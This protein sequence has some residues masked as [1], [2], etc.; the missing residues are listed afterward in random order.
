[1][2]TLE[3][4]K[5]EYSSDAIAL[6]AYITNSPTSLQCYSEA[7]IKSQGS[8]SLKGIASTAASG[9]T[10][11]HNLSCPTDLT[12]VNN[13]TFDLRSSRTGENIKLGLYS[14]AVP[15]GG[16]VFLSGGYE[17]HVFNQSG[18]FVLP[19]AATAEVLMVA[20]GGAGGGTSDGNGSGGGGAGGLLFYGTGGPKTPNGAA[21]SLTPGVYPVTV[22][23]GGVAANGQQGNNGGNTTFTSLIASGGGGGGNR[24]AGPGKAGGSGGGGTNVQPN[25]GAGVTGQGNKGG[26]GSYNSPY[27]GAGGGGGASAAGTNGTNMGGGVGGA[28]YSY[29]TW[30]GTSV[31]DG[32]A[33]AG[34]GGGE[35]YT[36]A[37]GDGA[38]GLGGGG[39]GRWGT[40]SESGVPNSGGGGGGAGELTNGAAG[41]GGDGIVIIKIP[42]VSTTEKLSITPNITT[43]G[44]FQ[45]IDWDISETATADKNNLNHLKIEIVNATAANTFYIDNL[46]IAPTQTLIQDVLGLIE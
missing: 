2:A 7:T 21:I 40:P 13:L 5:M 33:F 16:S 36:A 14:G 22:G 10:I 19:A 29:A 43:A 42:A 30:C 1:M 3:I 26:D 6:S 17:F 34:G 44:E 37:G 28:G 9:M 32:G 20:G 27:Y 24:T 41:S 46:Q 39:D 12:G 15:L 45:T 8:Y 25:G 38:G 4:D 31:G 35:S 18:V 11:S 23:T